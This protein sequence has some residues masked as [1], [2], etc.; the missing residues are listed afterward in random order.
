MATARNSTSNVS[1]GKGL[2]GGYL[3]SG[4][5]TETV[6]TDYNTPLGPEFVNVGFISSD[7]IN[8]V[9]EADTTSFYDM[10]G[11]PVADAD[12]SQTHNWAFT[13]IETKADALKEQYGH[14]N[15]TDEDGMITVV[16][17]NTGFEDRIYVAETILRD[18]RRARLILPNARHLA[19]DE[20][21][22]NS[23]NLFGRQVTVAGHTDEAGNTFYHYYQSTETDSP[24]EDKALNSGEVMGVD[25]SKFGSFDIQ[26]RHILGTAEKV[27]EGMEKLYGADMQKGYFMARDFEPYEGTRVRVKRDGEWTDWKNL[28]DDGNLIVFLGKDSIVATDLELQT[29]DGR[30]KA[31][32]IHVTAAKE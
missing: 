29:A 27:E 12:S 20:L 7:G 32:E 10:N 13:L 31:Y 3:F 16:G 5:I 15:V 28:K 2:K 23:E 1:V 17:N 18:G 24:V 22:I 26:G 6:P 21:N 4:P 9:D 8:I 14:K 19:T 25:V 30:I 11:D